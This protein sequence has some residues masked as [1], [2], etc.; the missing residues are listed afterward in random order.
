MPGAHHG[1]AQLQ[2]KA[3]LA[4]LEDHSP[5]LGQAQ[6]LQVGVPGVSCETPPVLSLSTLFEVILQH[7]LKCMISF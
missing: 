2:A 7:C 6:L 5:G 4:A 1:A 3:G